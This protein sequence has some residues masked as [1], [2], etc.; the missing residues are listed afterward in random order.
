MN[1]LLIQIDGKMPNLALMRLAAH[2]RANGDAVFL[3]HVNNADALVPCWW[4]DWDRI[5]ASAIF[6]RSD[7]I[8]KRVREVYPDAIIGGTGIDL[9]KPENE[10]QTLEAH[11]IGKRLDYGDYPAC[12]YS[13]GFTQ[14]GCRLKCHFCDVWLKEGKVKAAATIREV[15]RGEPWPR[16][17]MLLDND[18]FGQT[19]WRELCEEMLA[20]KFK[21]CFTQGINARMLNPLAAQW[22]AR[23]RCTDNKFERRRIYTAW[24]SI[25]DEC[26]LMRGLNDLVNA[27]FKPDEIEVY[28]LVAEN[29]PCITEDDLYRHRKLR[30]FGC[31]PFPM[32]FIRNDETRGF[33]RWV[34]RRGDFKCSWNNFKAANYRPEK[35]GMN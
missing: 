20:G 6:T 19:G 35:V 32:P 22:L 8:I 30:E 28:M 14:R 12:R 2:H 25:G 27:G 9:G 34:V 3:R 21:V 29:E 7:K 1:V 15:W 17:L 33:Q 23:L 31:R 24:D 18:F 16:H 5:Y 13:I 11:G 26:P 10:R 4:D